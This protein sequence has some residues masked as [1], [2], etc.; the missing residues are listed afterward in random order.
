MSKLKALLPSFEATPNVIVNYT[1]EMR[2]KAI[3]RSDAYYNLYLS[4]P[5]DSKEAYNSLY[6]AAVYCEVSAKILNFLNT[7]RGF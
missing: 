5:K 7:K 6:A 2:V 3:K 4:Q 1:Y